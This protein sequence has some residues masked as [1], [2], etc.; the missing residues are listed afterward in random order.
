MIRVC[1]TCESE[2]KPAIMGEKA[3]FEDRSLTHGICAAHKEAILAEIR[4]MRETREAV[5]LGGTR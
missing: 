1:A 5:A 3:P 2:G 4:R